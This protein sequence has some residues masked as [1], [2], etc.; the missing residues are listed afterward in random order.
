MPTKRGDAPLSRSPVDL[1][2][3]VT[4][5]QQPNHRSVRICMA[6]SSVSHFNLRLILACDH[7]LMVTPP[8]RCRAN[9]YKKFLLRSIGL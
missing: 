3:R 8:C 4:A 9:H 6:K 5:Y 2:P 7:S 1:L